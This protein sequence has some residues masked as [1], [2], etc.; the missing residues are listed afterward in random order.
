MAPSWIRYQTQPKQI[1][2]ELRTRS[3]NPTLTDLARRLGV[4]RWKNG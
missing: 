1:V 3:A 4:A 2:R